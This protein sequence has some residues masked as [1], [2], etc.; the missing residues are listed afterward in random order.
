MIEVFKT[1]IQD[2]AEASLVGLLLKSNYKLKKVSLTFRIV[3]EFLKLNPI[4]LMQFKI[5]EKL[6]HLGIQCS[7]LPKTKINN[8]KISN[9]NTP[10]C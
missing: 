3:T 8:E 6:S 7:L 9:C 1:D 2:V 10:R 4:K 5:V